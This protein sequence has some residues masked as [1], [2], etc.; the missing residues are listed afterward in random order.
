MGD[1][2]THVRNPLSANCRLVLA[3]KEK[4]SKRHHLS[5]SIGTINLISGSVAGVF[6]TE[7][8]AQQ[9]IKPERFCCVVF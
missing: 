9:G 8:I 7:I 1:S 2:G 6:V 4:K 5:L 3:L